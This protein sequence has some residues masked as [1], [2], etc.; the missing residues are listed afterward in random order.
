M[1]YFENIETAP[2]W[3]QVCVVLFVFGGGINLVA[4]ALAG[5]V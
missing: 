5:L 1:N 3:Q 4:G 2:V